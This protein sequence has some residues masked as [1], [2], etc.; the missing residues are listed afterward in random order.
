MAID[1]NSDLGEGFG[2][3]SLGSEEAILP[4][5]TSANLAC[6]FHAGEPEVM[7]RVVRLCQKHGVAVG[8][9]PGFPDLL[10]FGRRV[11]ETFPGQT[12]D[13]VLY[14]IAALSG[15]CRAEGADL[16]HVKPHGALYNLIAHDEGKAREVIAAVKEFDPNLILVLLGG[17]PAVGWAREAGVKV[18]EE[19]FAD[20]AYQPDGRL[21][22]RTQ[23]GAVIH[24]PEA[25]VE[26]VLGLARDKVMLS[27]AGG[28]VRVEA[29]TICLHGDTPGAV[30]LARTISQALKRN[31]LGPRPMSELV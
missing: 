30:E 26:R 19:A 1:L 8:A 9:H 27:A 2:R 13:Y 5:I 10:G 25:I 24:D 31:D 11:M 22:P 21:V 29:Q 6:G 4:Y 15:F 12:R 18:A 20:R 14:Q 28:A 3:W 17:S 16:V 7:R 23:P